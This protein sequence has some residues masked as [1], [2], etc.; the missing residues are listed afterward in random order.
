MFLPPVE[1]DG[2]ELGRVQCASQAVAV[3]TASSL[4]GSMTA[5]ILELRFG[6]VSHD[7]GMF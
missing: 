4:D 7:G 5:E 3:T 6:D 2:E 1:V